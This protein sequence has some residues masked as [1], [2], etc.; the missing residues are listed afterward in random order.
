MEDKLGVIAEIVP[1][2]DFPVVSSENVQA[3]GKRL[4]KALTDVAADVTRLE[5]KVDNFNVRDGSITEEKMDRAFLA[6]LRENDLCTV[7]AMPTAATTQASGDCFVIRTKKKIILVDSGAPHSYALIKERLEELGITKINYVI[8]SHYHADH[9]DNFEDL[10][11]DFDLSDCIAYLPKKSKKY[12]IARAEKTI[13]LFKNNVVIYPDTGHK[14]LVD[15]A[16]IEFFNCSQED[17]DYYDANTTN[18]NNQSVCFYLTVGKSTMLFTGDIA[19]HAQDRINDQGYFRKVDILKVHHHGFDKTT[20][21]DYIVITNPE[22]SLVP[23]SGTGTTVTDGVTSMVSGST[24]SKLASV[25]SKIV[26]TGQNENVSVIFSGV[27]YKVNY[28]AET[29]AKMS[30]GIEIIVYCDKTYDGMI[31]DGSWYHPFRSVQEAVNSAAQYKNK[32]RIKSKTATA[33]DENVVINCQNLVLDLGGSSIRSLECISS[34]I[35]I[36]NLE[37]TGTMSIPVHFHKCTVQIENIDISGTPA[38]TSA[39]YTG[40]GICF[41]FSIARIVNANFSG[42]TM[43]VCAYDASSVS[44]EKLTGSVIYG[45]LLSSAASIYVINRSNLTLAYNKLAYITSGGNVEGLDNGNTSQMNE[46]LMGNSHKGET[47]FNTD[48]SKLMI[49]NGSN[50]E[51]ANESSSDRFGEYTTYGKEVFTPGELMPSNF[52]IRDGCKVRYNNVVWS[53]QIYLSYVSNVQ[54]D[55]WTTMMTISE[56]AMG[57]MEGNS[58]P[59]TFEQPVELRSI[60]NSRVI[61]SDAKI[62]VLAS[63]EVQVWSPEAVTLNVRINTTVLSAIKESS[64]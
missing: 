1:K 60:D 40:R 45:V 57:R 28:D 39:Y 33:Y 20:N 36:V 62:R 44:V 2:G 12:E 9:V 61:V 19:G 50:W 5:E 59:I 51:V 43:A 7:H 25:H 15:D 35:N 10:M 4:D 47:F 52:L 27:N 3:G 41:Y 29:S 56:E 17:F 21:S 30:E 37:V 63:G 16:L 31:C 14:L 46:Y 18:F 24:L 53:V 64:F 26:V 42:R 55:T 54:A 38:D 49:W 22:Y 32:T 23:M 48:T 34:E 11:R 13:E 58:V 8:V 6:D